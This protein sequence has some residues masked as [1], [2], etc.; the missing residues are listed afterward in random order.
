MEVTLDITGMTCASCAQRIERKLNKQDGVSAAV[1]YALESAHITTSA[2]EGSATPSTEELVQLVEKMGYGATVHPDAAAHPTED[3]RAG[4]ASAGGGSADQESSELITLRQRLLGALWLSL[5]VIVL[6]MIPPLQFTNWQW[7]SLTLAAPVVVW[8]G[9]PFHKAAW[10]NLKQGAATMDTLISVGTIAAFVW[11][12]V[13]LFF[14]SAGEPGMRHG[15]SLLRHAGADPWAD[16]YLEVASGVILFV[17]AGRYFEKKSKKTA[18]D[19]LRSL[20]HLGAKDVAVLRESAAGSSKRTEVRVPIAELQVGDLFVARPGEKIATDGEVVS[21]HGAVNEAMLTGESLPREVSPGD[22]VT[23][24]T[25]NESGFLTIRATS[26]GAETTL[27]QMISLVEQAQSGKAQ[28]QRLADRVAGVFVPVVI[29]LAVLVAVGWWWYGVATGAANPWGQAFRCAV[30][31]LI[32]ACPCA[33]GLATPTALLVGTG[34][35]ASR[36]ILIHGPEVLEAA[37]D[38]SVVLFDKT[39]TLTTGVMEVTAVH[40]ASAPG[41]AVLDEPTVLALAAAVEAGSEHPIGQAIVRAA[42][43]RGVEVPEVEGFEVLPGRGVRG[44]VAGSGLVEVGRA[45]GEGVAESSAAASEV[46]EGGATLV[47]V[48]LEGAVIGRVLLRDAVK[49]SSVQA[50]A[51]VK[52]L[53]LRPMLLTGDRRDTAVA[54]AREVGIAEADVVAE[55]M[56]EDK[57][58]VVADMQ[59]RGEKVAMVGDGINDAA[60]LVQANA[61]IAM[62]SGADV[63]INAADITLM[64]NDPRAVAEALGMSRK[65]LRTIKGNLFWAFAYN[66]AAIPVAA[67][68]LLNPMLAGAAMALSSVFVVSNSLRLRRG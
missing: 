24:A 42:A 54:V 11:S 50:I 12:V 49:E 36:G 2:G 37:Q 46:S 66:V 53:G 30:A 10:L 21:G 40:T 19:A 44:S 57:L 68:G 58:A 28:V 29:A 1:N 6:A 55:V 32:I 25:I 67:S 18:G 52:A 65:T 56:P 39:G 63:A 14:G 35:A 61:G 59:R 17:L 34:R 47:V 7:L 51:A 64:R 26:V 16:I 4:E 15:W 48:S 43:D 27:A 45:H 60:A 13:A 8:A 9:W 41:Q 62:G 31:V 3:S 22:G 33:L 20:A 23:G 38:V 5:P